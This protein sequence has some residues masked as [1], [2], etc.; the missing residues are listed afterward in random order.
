MIIQ[1]TINDNDFTER[2]ERFFNR[3][4]VNCMD[5]IYNDG[6]DVIGGFDTFNKFQRL[7][8]P[9]VT[10]KLKAEDKEFLKEI[11]TAAI[12]KYYNDEYISNNLKVEILK[13]YTD[14][15]ENGEVIYYFTTHNVHIVN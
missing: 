12:K 9:N 13:T 10:T 1:A 7:L 3:F 15:W 6:N 8:N 4:H 2:L 5:Y 14:K 11:I